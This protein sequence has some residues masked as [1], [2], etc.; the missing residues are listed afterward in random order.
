MATLLR[1]LLIFLLTQAT[2]HNQGKHKEKDLNNRNLLVPIKLH[3]NQVQAWRNLIHLKSKTIPHQNLVQKVVQKNQILIIL[4]H[5]LFPR[6]S[7]RNLHNLPIRFIATRQSLNW[8]WTFNQLLTILCMIPMLNYNNCHSIWLTD[9]M[10]LRKVAK[11]T[12]WMDK[13]P[14]R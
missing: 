11:A 5:S 2:D 1:D 12:S 13:Q 9:S 4:Q 3:L 10:L 7:N 14:E 8:I 6:K